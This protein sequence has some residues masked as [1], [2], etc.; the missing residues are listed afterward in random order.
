MTTKEIRDKLKCNSTMDNL[1]KLYKF[2]EIL[3]KEDATKG[4]GRRFLWRIK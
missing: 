2:G 3:R 4:I 1:R